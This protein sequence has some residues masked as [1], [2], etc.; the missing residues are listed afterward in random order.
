MQ[1]GAEIVT[2]E[3]LNWEINR[4]RISPTFSLCMQGVYKAM[5]YGL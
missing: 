4:K 5:C 1:E 3:I 2:I